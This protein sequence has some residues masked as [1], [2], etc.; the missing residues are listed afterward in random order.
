MQVMT[1]DT[2]SGGATTFGNLSL[3]RDHPAGGL[4]G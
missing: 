4:E 1:I 3:A 2:G